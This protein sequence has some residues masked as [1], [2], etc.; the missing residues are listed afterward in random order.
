MLGHETDWTF[1]HK[2]NLE[3]LLSVPF[4]F[5]WSYVMPYRVTIQTCQT[6]FA[7]RLLSLQ[8]L[9][10]DSKVQFFRKIVVFVS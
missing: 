7:L 4:I 1:S 6:V 10:R 9:F 2:A 5:T 8:R 3:L